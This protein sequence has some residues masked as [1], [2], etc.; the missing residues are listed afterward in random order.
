[1]KVFSIVGMG[2][3]PMPATFHPWMPVALIYLTGILLSVRSIAT[4]SVTPRSAMVFLLTAIGVV[5]FQ[6]YLGR[7]H[8]WNLF[9]SG[10]WCFMLLTVYADDALT[11][12]KSRRV[13]LLPLAVLLFA[14]SF[15]VF[16][17]A[18]DAGGIAGLMFE[19]AA[20]EKNK[21]EQAFIE[22]NAESI[23]SATHEKEPV[24][25][26]SANYYQGL[27]Y[28]LSHTAAA[29]NPGM[30]DLFLRSDYERILSFIA[31]NTAV[32]IFYDAGSFRCVRPEI[33]IL[34]SSLYDVRSG[35]GSRGTILF[36]TKKPESAGSGFLFAQD[37]ASYIH[38]EFDNNPAARVH[39]AEGY[40]S[41]LSLGTRFSIQVLFRPAVL[42][43]PL[44]GMWQ[45]VF[46]NREN[47][48]DASGCSLQRTDRS[49]GAYT[50]SIGGNSIDCPVETGAWNYLAYEVNDQRLRIFKNGRLMGV[51][52]MPS[53]YR[54]SGQPLYVG[55]FNAQGAMFWG[56]IREIAIT[57][58]LLDE[59]VVAATWKKTAEML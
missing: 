6:Y 55:N 52:T 48:T 27:Y 5:S 23:R 38:E 32:K 53:T 10:P 12:V 36:L 39:Y 49:P 24:M 44:A 22:M 14:L 8:N 56:D 45:T 16:Q 34:L 37:T 1:M 54:N 19:T 57:G 33:P 11:V 7:S 29:L 46:N 3:L 26:F 51:L 25:I 28:G 18:G 20:K 40:G 9:S 50:F 41:S 30:E 15:S 43:P 4:R 58:S 13:F 35:D 31:E 17:V 2:M 59:K 21:N 47:L 42:P